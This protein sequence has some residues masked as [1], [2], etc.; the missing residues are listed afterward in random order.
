MSVSV[1]IITHDHIG[2]IILDAAIKII[3]SC[4]MPIHAIS[5]EMDCDY[6]KKIIE[7]TSVLNELDNNDGLLLLT[8][9][10]G[11]TPSNIATSIDIKNS[12]IVAGLNLPMLIRVMNYHTL[13]LYELGDKAIGGGKDGVLT[14]YTDTYNKNATIKN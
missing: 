2:Q 9:L 4:P 10:Y 11:A 5:I 7:I 12:I 1:L 13:P 14:Y 3:G 6:D 8:D